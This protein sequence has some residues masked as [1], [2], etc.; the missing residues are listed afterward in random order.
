MKVAYGP[1]GQKGVTALVAIGDTDPQ[2]NTAEKWTAVAGVG[3][4]AVG[5]LAGSK[6]AAWGGLGV[7]AGVLFARWLRSRRKVEVTTPTT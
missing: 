6:R 3:L 1:P 7:L 5:G 2:Q 4:A